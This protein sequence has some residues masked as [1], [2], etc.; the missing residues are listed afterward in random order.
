MFRFAAVSQ[1]KKGTNNNRDKKYFS[2]PQKPGSQQYFSGPRNTQNYCHNQHKYNSKYEL[3]ERWDNVSGPGTKNFNRNRRLNHHGNNNLN[4]PA[5]SR[6]KV[7]TLKKGNAD[8]KVSEKKMPSLH[9]R[10]KYI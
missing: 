7:G 9:I 10:G 2:A 4:E 8:Q 5:I 1:K 6:A 3:N